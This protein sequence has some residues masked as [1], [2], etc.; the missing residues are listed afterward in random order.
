M[1]QQPS[2]NRKHVGVL[3]T[4]TRVAIVMMQIPGSPLK[5][6]VAE[7]DS[8]PPYHEELLR[9]VLNSQ[10]AQSASSLADVMG[11]TN[12]PG[13]GRSLMM[14]FHINKLMRAEPVENIYLTPNPQTKQ[15]LLDVL[16]SMGKFGVDA[17]AQLQAEQAA[18]QAQ[19]TRETQAAIESD[20]QAIAKGLL[21]EAEMME[22][23]AATKRAHA[24][25]LCPSLR[26][27]QVAIEEVSTTPSTTEAS[28]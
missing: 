8:L 28:A 23:V 19:E 27:Q 20:P 21:V 24:Y 16:K 7:L 1:F 18:R 2:Q 9:N 12:V 3:K 6:L 17:A 22:Q 5:A 26:P 10:N 11:S 15:S 13:I 25:D 14:D 4:G